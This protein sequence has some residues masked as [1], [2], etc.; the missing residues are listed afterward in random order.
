MKMKID[1]DNME[2]VISLGVSKSGGI[3]VSQDTDL[4]YI[5]EDK[6]EEFI[7]AFQSIAKP[8]WYDEDGEEVV[9][10]EGA[11][12]ICV[13]AEDCFVRLDQGF[14]RI[15]IMNRDHAKSIAEFL[16]MLVEEEA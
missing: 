9:E 2:L 14:N 10:E 16:L 5:T 4:I 6:I 1:S 13:D 15:S 11:V 3:E 12:D 7:A 8:I